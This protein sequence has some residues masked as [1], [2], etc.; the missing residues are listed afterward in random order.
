M[1]RLVDWL[2]DTPPHPLFLF[3]LLPLSLQGEGVGHV[4]AVSGGEEEEE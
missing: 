2:I 1:D 3:L 4:W